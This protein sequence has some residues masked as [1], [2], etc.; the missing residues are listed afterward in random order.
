MLLIWKLR[1]IFL[2]VPLSG[3]YIFYYCRL[4]KYS[5]IKLVSFSLQC[6][7]D[8][9]V[10]SGFCFLSCEAW[11]NFTW[12]IFLIFTFHDVLTVWS[13]YKIYIEIS[14]LFHC[15]R[16]WNF[17]TWYLPL[18]L[19]FIIER[20]VF[21][22]CLLLVDYTSVFLIEVSNWATSSL[23]MF[24]IWSLLN[25][26]DFSW[27]MDMMHWVYKERPHGMTKLV[28]RWFH[29]LCYLHGWGG[30]LYTPES[31]QLSL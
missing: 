5:C 27:K 19:V 17:L 4:Q 10:I 20:C 28:S 2:Y 12:K 9:G 29:E 22:I 21:H 8:P 7:L 26:L 6:L 13:W 14:V 24:I 15:C 3:L 11:Y 23:T 30:K 31:F 18:P 16:Y 25:V 1:I